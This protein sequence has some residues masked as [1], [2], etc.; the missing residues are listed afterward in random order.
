MIKEVYVELFHFDKKTDYLPYYKK[1]TV[2]YNDDEKII[3]LL[4]KLYAI[5]PF[6]FDDT[7]GCKLKINGLYL[8]S[9]E[10]ITTVVDRVGTN[11]IIKP[12]SVYRA[13]K[14]LIVDKTDFLNKIDMYKNY[15]SEEEKEFY[16]KNFELEYYASNS[17]NINQDY[18]G[19]HA[20]LIAYDIIQKH[21]ETKNEVLKFI[22]DKVDGIWFHTSLKHRVLNFKADQED[23]IRE[24]F[25][26][27]PQSRDFD[28]R[29]E[30]TATH[31]ISEISQSFKGFNIASYNGQENCSFED[32][33]QKSEANYI[34]M[35][36]KNEDL[37]PYSYVADSTFSYKVAG[38]ILLQAKDNNADFII[39]RD[40]R[41]L[42]LFDKRQKR[43][44]KA[45]GREIGMPVVLREQFIE[46][47]KGEKDITKLG[48]DKHKVKID[49]L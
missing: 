34:D 47:L 38:Q 37:A 11:L 24:L 26:M 48:F 8:T 27:M 45:V 33:I 4:N 49:F 15:L 9:D 29:K 10:L 30:Y 32:I 46:L 22:D 2:R 42:Y 25:T 13:K 43:V 20:L 3:D 35:D 16:T 6:G 36:S 40:D 41:D 1:Y 21:P 31:S 7:N 19:D 5:E 12:V 23:K 17:L 39:V 44:E 28:P 14:D 18:I